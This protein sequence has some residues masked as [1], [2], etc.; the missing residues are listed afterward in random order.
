MRRLSPTFGLLAAIALPGVLAAQDVPTPPTLRLSFY[1]CDMNQLGPTGQQ[2][3]NLEIPIWDE[4]VDEG[5]VQS[6]GYFFH[7]WASEWNVGIYTIAADIPA[8]LSATEEFGNRMQERHP[9]A[10]G[11]LNQVCPH[12]RDGFYTLGPRTGMADEPGGGGNR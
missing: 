5:M 3:E 9:D 4:L 1:E 8:I 11:G 2:I 12:H 7:S 6:Y 10:D